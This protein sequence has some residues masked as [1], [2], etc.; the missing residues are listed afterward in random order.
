MP[1]GKGVCV[2]GNSAVH[3]DGSMSCWI[4]AVEPKN[5]TMVCCAAHGILGGGRFN[6]FYQPKLL[7][8]PKPVRLGV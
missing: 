6:L 1:T 3:D 4:T 2:D 8:V 5:K 7:N